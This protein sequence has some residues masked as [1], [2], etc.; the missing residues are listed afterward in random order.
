DS[1]SVEV[2]IDDNLEEYVLVKEQDGKL[3]IGLESGHSY[4]TTLFIARVKAPHFRLVEGSGG[5]TV[6]SIGS[7]VVSAPFAVD[8]SGGS[9]MKASAFTDDLN[10]R[11]SGGSRLILNGS[12]G[13]LNLCVSGG[14]EA[15]MFDF[16]VNDCN[17]TLSGGSSAQISASGVICGE[18][19]GGS[20]LDYCGNAA[21]G[22]VQKS[23][24][25]TVERRCP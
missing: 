10:I 12:G 9:E 19:S 11:L 22:S 13:N 16:D 5:S 15:E 25:S 14:G 17:A 4:R 20:D 1:F 24:G 8:L 2:T 23:G 7:V 6:E 3:T 18:L 21:V